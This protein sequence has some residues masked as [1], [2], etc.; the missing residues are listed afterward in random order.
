MGLEQLNCKSISY[1]R[2]L[3]WSSRTWYANMSAYG[4][5]IRNLQLSCSKYV[6]L[7][8][9]YGLASAR[10]EKLRFGLYA[11]IIYH[12]DMSKISENVCSV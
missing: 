2:K 10:L 1:T 9:A 6:I 3:G 11:V 8:K 7:A 4:V 12:Q 5:L